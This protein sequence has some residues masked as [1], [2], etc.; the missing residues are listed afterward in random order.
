[1]RVARGH[2]LSLSEESRGRWPKCIKDEEPWLQSGGGGPAPSCS[3]AVWNK[4]RLQ[5]GRTQHPGP[6]LVAQFPRA[7]CHSPGLGLSLQAAL[8]G[9]WSLWNS[10]TLSLSGREHRQ[11]EAMGEEAGGPPKPGPEDP[12]HTPGYE[13][14]SSVERPSLVLLLARA[15]PPSSNPAGPLPQPPHSPPTQPINWATSADQDHT[16]SR[17]CCPALLGLSGSR[18]CL[19]PPNGSTLVMGQPHGGSPGWAPGGLLPVEPHFIGAWPS[20]LQV[21]PEAPATLC[22][23]GSCVPHPTAL[24]CWELHSGWENPLCSTPAPS[25]RVLRGGPLPA[26]AP[27][28]QV[29]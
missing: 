6:Q 4:L 2:F 11:R 9:L 23:Q 21:C 12:Q 3:L 17:A 14:T 18:L 5:S 24:R 22:R 25:P 16:R 8:P 26:R 27:P 28:R 29:L 15:G 19:S 13:A 10:T 7:T 1:M 20:P